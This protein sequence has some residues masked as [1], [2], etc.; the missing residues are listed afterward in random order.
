MWTVQRANPGC[1]VAPERANTSGIQQTNQSNPEPGRPPRDRAPVLLSKGAE[2]GDCPARPHPAAGLRRCPRRAGS[3]LQLSLPGETG[4]WPGSR[5]QG[6]QARTCVLHPLPSEPHARAQLTRRRAR[7]RR[8]Q[9]AAGL[10]AGPGQVCPATWSRPARDRKG[11]LNFLAPEKATPKRVRE[12]SS[13]L[14]LQVSTSLHAG[15]RCVL[16]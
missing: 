6:E 11:A 10:C 15:V 8:E 7:Y 12:T 9:S 16:I 2:D 14:S 13:V 5:R 4:T 3:R 1:I